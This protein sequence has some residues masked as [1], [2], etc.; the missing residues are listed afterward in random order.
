[1]KRGLVV[2]ILLILILPCVTAT[3]VSL[4][5]PTNDAYNLGDKIIPSGYIFADA[6]I[7]AYLGFSVICENSTF[8]LQRVAV[9]M[10]S[11]QQLFFPNDFSVPTL[12]LS[13]SMTGTCSIQAEIIDSG[14]NVFAATSTDPFQVTKELN[15]IFDIEEQ[16]VQIGSSMVLTATVTK[17]D[18]TGVTASAEI[19]FK[20]NDSK[21]L[22]DIV[23]FDTVLY[24]VHEATPSTSGRYDLDI[25][26]R[27]IYGN[28]QLFVDAATFTLVDELYIFFKTL[29][30][31]LRPSETLEVFGEVK[32]ILQTPVTEGTVQITL[33]SDTYTTMLDNGAYEY[34]LVV[35]SYIA[36]GTQTVYAEVT[37]GLGNSGTSNLN[38]NIIAVASE[39][40]LTI[41]DNEVFPGE[42]LKFSAIIFDQAY[43]LMGGEMGVSLYD[44][45]DELLSVDTALAG[46]EM[47]L[48]FP[49]TAEP[50]IWHLQMSM[51]DVTVR[52]IVK[53]GQLYDLTVT[54]DNQ[55]ILIENT[56][57]MKYKDDIEILFDSGLADY[58]ISKRNSLNVG[59]IL[60]VN[61]P[62]EVPS[63]IYT[64][65]VGDNVFEEVEVV[66]GK[67]RASLDWL[68]TLI[69]I[70]FIFLLV[71]MAYKFYID[72]KKGGRSIW[73]EILPSK[74]HIRKRKFQKHSVEIEKIPKKV[75]GAVKKFKD[76][77]AHESDLKDFRERILKDIKKV[78]EKEKKFFGSNKKGEFAIPKFEEPKKDIPTKPWPE[79][80]KEKTQPSPEPPTTEKKK[81]D[82]PVSG[83]AGFFSNF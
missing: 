79:K 59:E 22:I 35:P 13:S 43:D 41:E 54:L 3:T 61:M 5:N 78:E 10:L 9:N 57:N 67:T 50:G 31:S 53:I 82:P 48:A 32:T 15:G 73:R 39:I 45:N 80:A 40:N 63:G 74:K 14:N 52:E 2:L 58:T 83:A 38:I 72:T 75:T 49:S 20:Q 34:N 76:K 77:L 47:E 66:G 44:P 36:S 60:E 56:G 69:L 27:D 33:G 7:D 37:D 62:D 70:L 19:Y 29:Q 4:N 16:M 81:E 24:Y 64:V 12:T 25:L 6:D 26:V 55:T 21:Y 28:E 65:T 11:G 18:D 30:G 71:Y 23:D 42:T 51:D 17:L 1:M 46:E 8:N 68:Y